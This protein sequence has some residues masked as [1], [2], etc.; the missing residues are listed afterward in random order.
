MHRF[1]EYITEVIG[2]LRIMASP[3]LI[4]IGL[5][6]FIYLSNPT[7]TRLILAVI[8]ACIGFIVGAIWA[9]KIW[10]SKNGTM[11]FVS[12]TMATPELDDKEAHDVTK[13]VK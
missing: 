6:A 10:K 3:L 4:G 11:W 13:E 1:F 2:W 7:H 9:T 12:R 8:V 5:G